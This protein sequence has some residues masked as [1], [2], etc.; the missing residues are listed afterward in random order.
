MTRVWPGT[1]APL[2]ATFDGEGTNFALFSEHATGVDLCLF[3]G[4]AAAVESARIPL[5][6]RTDMVWHAY[7]PDVRPGQLYGYRVHGPYAPLEGHRFNAAKLL[8]DPYAKAISGTVQ[9]SEAQFGYPLGGPQGDLEPARGDSAGGMPKCIVAESAFSWGNDEPPQVPWNRTVIYEAHVKAM[10]M[11]HPDVPEELRGTYLGLATD[12]IIDHL[13]SLGITAFELM[14]VHQF[15]TERHLHDRSLHNFWGYS[16]IGFFAPDVRYAR[17]GLGEQVS[18]FKT[19]VKRF[20]GAGIEVILDVV[21]NHTGEGNHLGPTLCFRGI[22]NRSYYRLQPEDPRHYRDFTGTGNSLNLPHPRVMQLVMDSLRYWVAEMHVDG[23]RFDLATTLARDPNDYRR[24]A[25]FFDII[26]QDPLLSRVKL[27]AEPWDLGHDGYQVG[28]FP[29]GWAEW[30]AQY[31]D[32]VRRFWCGSPGEVSDLGYR[33]SG[34]SDLYENSGRSPYSSI[35]FVTAHDGFTLNDLV[36][37]ERKHNEANG[38]G[39]RDGTDHNLSCNWGAEGPTGNV[40]IVALRDRM[41]RNFLAT[42]ACSQGIPMLLYGDEVG[43]TQQGNNN[44][45]AQDSELTWMDWDLNRRQR[46]LLA[47]TRRAFG[48]RRANPVLQRR[49]YFHGRPIA[50]AG[51]KDVSWHRPDGAE[52][53]DA[54]WRNPANHVLGMLVHGRS[55]DATDPHGR[56]LVGETLLLLLNGG[57]R[58][59]HFTLPALAEPGGWIEILNTV[60]PGERGIASAA[61]NLTARS[62]ILL[63]HERHS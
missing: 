26:R 39:N 60:R 44:A 38:E 18:E 36:S 28:G 55:T 59:R 40:R 32:T 15:V 17:A 5:Q 56:L 50:E 30:N 6:E 62:V 34:S 9:W 4:A 57:G 14:P 25:R 21:Y 58:S 27:I 22:D 48:I 47:F 41:R 52:M 23:F 46:E 31:R 1:P 37:Y 20:H 10:T 63:R 43:R 11:R 8:L 54:D 13:R 42:L 24:D 33:L 45:Y 29:V 16:S 19:M 61:V 7:L 49:T 51:V 2:G 35:N 3:D 12:P 53:T